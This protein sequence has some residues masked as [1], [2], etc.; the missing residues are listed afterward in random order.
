MFGEFGDGSTPITKRD[1]ISF[2]LNNE[3]NKKKLFSFSSTLISKAGMGGTL[4]LSIR[5]QTMLSNKHGYLKT[6]KH[7]RQTGSYDSLFP[8]LSELLL[9]IVKNYCDI[10]VHTIYPVI[11]SL[12]HL[13]N[14]LDEANT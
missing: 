14:C 2:F 6:P 4:L 3:E 10:Q 7:I 1:W 13:H 8:M 5:F 9:N 11:D 12:I